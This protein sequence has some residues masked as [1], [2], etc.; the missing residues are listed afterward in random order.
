[1]TS[2]SAAATRSRVARL[3]VARADF[4]DAR[5]ALSRASVGLHG[6][7]SGDDDPLWNLAKQVEGLRDQV[8]AGFDA[9]NEM[10]WR[11]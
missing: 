6:M 9:V 7:A 2:L 5:D 4:L 10:F 1:M 3:A 8:N 11:A